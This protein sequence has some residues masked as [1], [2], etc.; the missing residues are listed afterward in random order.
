LL[1]GCKKL[2]LYIRFEGK[3]VRRSKTGEENMHA[4]VTAYKGLLVL[5][6]RVEKSIENEVVSSLDKPGNLG[7]IIMDSA[8]NVGISEQAL[9][10]LKTV[11]RGSDSLGDID[12]FKSGDKAVFGWLGGPYRIADPKVIEGSREYGIFDHVAI[13][14]DVP[15]GAKEAIDEE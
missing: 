3:F 7:Q 5:E 11:R 8:K 13:P 9:A 2:H 14:N 15:A 4:H 1:Y 12:W 10:L 6:L